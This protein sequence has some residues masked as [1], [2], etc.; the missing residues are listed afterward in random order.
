MVQKISVIIPYIENDNT[1]KNTV[2]S[3]L[4]QKKFNVEENAEILI[5]NATDTSI[6]TVVSLSPVI[7]EL[8]SSS[9]LLC[10]VLYFGI[11]HA[12]HPY[13]T[14]INCGDIIND[15]FFF[16]T[17]T[18]F[19]KLKHVSF[20]A[21]QS[22]C[23]NPSFDEEKENLLNCERFLQ[24]QVIDLRKTPES[25]HV[26]INAAVFQTEFIKKRKFDDS[27]KYESV[28][29]F[30]LCF[31]LE[32]H[33]YGTC[34]HAKY[35]YFMPQ[36]DDF[37]YHL[38]ANYQ[39]WYT[40][41]VIEFLLPLLEKCE[42]TYKK[43]PAFI[44]IYTMYML[45]AR[46]LSNLNNRN[47]RNMDSQQL[48]DFFISVKTVLHKIDDATIIN[49]NKYCNLTYSLECAQVFLYIKY[50][51]EEGLIPFDY[52]QGKEQIYLN[53][54]DIFMLTLAGQSANLHVMDYRN[55]KLFI[56]G[57]F[58]E[59]FN[60]NNLQLF[61]RFNNK[62]Y[63]LENNDRYS[64]TKYFGISAYK[65]FTFHI[66]LPLEEGDEIQKLSFYAKIKNTV[67]PL[68]IG[69]IHHWAKLAVNPKSSYWRFRD[70]IAFYNS[71]EKAIV[72]Q[73][74][75]AFD[76]FLREVK[77]LASTLP[78]SKN[79][80]LY[81]IAYWLTRPYFKQKRIWYMYDKMYKGGDSS[82]YMYR[83][84]KNKNDGVTRYYVIDKNTPDMRNFKKDG[85]KPVKNKSLFAK[86]AF[87]NADI[88]LITNANTFPFNGFTMDYSRFIRGFCNFQTMCLQHGLSVQKCAMAQQ[89]VVDNTVRYFVASKY[90]VGNLEHHAY[91]YEG[92]DI[93]K[94]T[95]IA[96]YDGLVSNDRRQ[97]LLSPTWRM[98]NA[99][100][101]KSSEGEQRDYNPEFKHT[102]Y[103]KI[104]ND[105]I[106]NEKLIQCAKETGYTIK[107]LLHPILSSQVE[108]FTVDNDVAEVISSV[109]D[110]SYEQILTESSLMVTDYSG[111]QFD[112]A[113]MK[114]PLVYFHPSKLPAHYEDG[115][116]F[117]DTMGFGEIC[118]ESEELV[119]TLCE[120]M[121]SNCVMKPEYVKRVDDFY[122]HNDHNNCER[123]YEEIYAYQKIV[124]TDK[125]RKIN[126]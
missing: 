98:Y 59:L 119:D 72:F 23:V 79:S 64:L 30:M 125:M 114:K 112:F 126:T 51:Y 8:K 21:A 90:E 39:D 53:Y 26:S 91:N 13:T 58:R 66:E 61:A 34:M 77:V 94:T 48:Q 121:K 47:K 123:I 46:F 28:T 82:E 20:I 7:K 18:S 14:V 87:F 80:F 62:E 56:D 103:F 88:V 92:F 32:H 6:D 116:F 9:L 12:E 99:M 118:T 85:F 106:N 109:G 10:D 84:C 29:D 105:L 113:Y 5:I 104:Y 36:E 74:A 50:G 40:K 122:V 71:E 43:I 1:L 120:Y 124:D 24:E 27:L 55:G 107:Y 11:N 100:P 38:Y 96:R 115:C 68:N 49:K 2:N 117:Y 63:K 86:L 44:R 93:I 37:Q 101:V 65:K 15:V 81:R 76:T 95:G 89:R 31:Q 54:K 83:Y 3:V 75:K 17:L 67:V 70:K 35:S 42:I 52:V 69:F 108:D 19:S 78:Q 4:Q 73:K 57:S 41:S 45:Q 25:F 16:D 102:V 60:R 33:R 111:V 22:N 97:I 110:M